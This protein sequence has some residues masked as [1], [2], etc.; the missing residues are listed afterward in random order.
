MHVSRTWSWEIAKILL[1][2][3]AVSPIIGTIIGF[4][5][6]GPLRHALCPRV[7]RIARR[8]GP[9]SPD[10]LVGACRGLLEAGELRR[11]AVSEDQRHR[12]H[13]RKSL[14]VDSQDEASYVPKEIRQLAPLEIEMRDDCLLLI[15]R[16]RFDRVALTVFPEGMK[17]RGSFELAEGLWLWDWDYP[18]AEGPVSEEY[19]ETLFPSL[20]VSGWRPPLG[21][22]IN[23][24]SAFLV[25][26]FLLSVSLFRVVKRL[27]HRGVFIQGVGLSIFKQILVCFVP[28]LIVRSEFI[29]YSLQRANFLSGTLGLCI[30]LVF[31]GIVA[32]LV[33]LVRWRSLFG[34]KRTH[35][36]RLFGVSRHELDVALDSLRHSG[37]PGSLLQDCIPRRVLRPIWDECWELSCKSGNR[38]IWRSLRREILNRLVA[39]K[40][41]Q[42]IHLGIINC[43]IRMEAL[44]V[45]ALMLKGSLGLG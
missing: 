14:R 12:R 10:D 35:R 9:V 34:K 41:D 29:G 38:Q 36:L 6:M 8:M 30:Q 19:G 16:I 33:L 23:L 15:L 4:V 28:L 44:F 26:V 43:G 2:L 40:P 25:S 17:G 7:V 22:E 37:E 27:T 39:A 20:L 21:A 5:A 31:F 3:L 18:S 11:D 42:S 1:V 32:C 24:M 45:L 13:P